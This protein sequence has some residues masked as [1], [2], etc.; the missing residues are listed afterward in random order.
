MPFSRFIES[1]ELDEAA[2]AQAAGSFVR[3]NAGFTHY[4][5]SGPEHAQLVIL[6]HGFSVPYFI[7][8]PTYAALT[9]AGFRVLRYDLFGRGY[10]DRPNLRYTLEFFVQQLADLLDALRLHAPLRLVGL[11]MGG[12]IASAFTVRFPAR[13]EKLAL[14]DPIGTHSMPLNWIYRLAIL[15]GVSEFLLQWFGAESMLKS[16]A[17]DFFDPALVGEFQDRYLVQ[18]QY[19]SFQRAILSTLRNGVV[20]GSPDTYEKLGKLTVPILLIWGRNDTT[21]P[22][23]QSRSILQLAPRTEFHIIEDTRHIPHYEKPDEVNP[24]LIDFLR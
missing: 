23:A 13:V 8:D 3:L 17:A 10:S 12:V 19:R 15:P 6:V 16:A 1:K 14:I 24:L 2:R 21:L 7:W 5:L 4:E 18:M 9:E 20:N 22:L 11:S